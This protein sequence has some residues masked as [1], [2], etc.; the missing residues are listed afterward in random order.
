[1]YKIIVMLCLLLSLP[2]SGRAADITTLNTE[3]ARSQIENDL[4]VLNVYRQG[5]A[6]N[7]DFIAGDKSL[8]PDKKTDALRLLA[9]NERETIRRYWQST[10]DYY[11]ALDSLGNYYHHYYNLNEKDLK[12]LSFHI[13]YEAFLTQ[14]RFALEI[15]SILE[16][17]P[18]L[19]TLLNEPMPELGL[20]KNTYQ[21]FKFRF[22][23]IARGA[24]FA[25]LDAQFHALNSPVPPRL[26][27]FIQE[28]SQYLWK[29]GK[30]KGIALTLKNGLEIISKA[31]FAAY[32]PV[33]S[34]V[35]EWMGATK[36]K[37]VHKSLISAEQIKSL[38]EVLQPG[39]ILL[40]RREWYLS[41]IGLPGFW[42]HAAL[43]IGTARQRA[44]YF[45]DPEVSEW[46][47]TQGFK[48]GN[49]ETMLSIIYAKAYDLSAKADAQ[50]ALPRILEAIGQGVS[51]TSLEH[52]ADCDSLVVLRPRLSKKNKALAIMKGFY[53][54]GRPYDFNFDFRTDAELVCT[55]LIFKT[56]E[57][58]PGQKGL[59]LHLI[60]YMG[61]LL[62]PANDIAKQFDEEFG[63]ADQQLDFVI[64]LDGIE[65]E[66]KA[67]VSTLA[68][69]RQTWK[70][71]KWH[72]LV[73]ERQEK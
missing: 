32:L 25:A 21:D 58:R 66:N 38:S 3:E 36:V 28:D 8:S 46:V 63:S 72:I 22:L 54:S 18:S 11:L 7:T 51:F 27:N 67:K 44:E 69:F 61:H 37:R 31:G 6:G 64:F 5:L 4:K 30:G 35:S 73:Q 60:N 14:Y 13:F 26:K 55:E 47:K 12:E 34:G 59:N 68:E 42:T 10:M 71:P 1:M 70:R 20:P 24:E 65:N 41:N 50:S 23:N 52:S 45:N 57:P 56:Y 2:L 17:E 40:E 53:Y 16:K 49:F 29:M 62:I 19:D 43:Y 39:D 9:L 48:D 33:Q 15:I